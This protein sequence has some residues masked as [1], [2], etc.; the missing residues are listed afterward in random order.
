MKSKFLGQ[1]EICFRDWL[2]RFIVLSYSFSFLPMFN[3][4]KALPTK[5]VDFLPLLLPHPAHER[6]A[7]ESYIRPGILSG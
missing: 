1:K 3:D 7:P 6:Q 5:T 4:L 2:G